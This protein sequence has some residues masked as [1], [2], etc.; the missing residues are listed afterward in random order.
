MD[1]V[2]LCRKVKETL[3]DLQLF[4]VLSFHGGQL[5]S[6]FFDRI[7]EGLEAP[8]FL[9]LDAIPGRGCVCGGDGEIVRE[10]V[11]PSK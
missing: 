2:D 3:P 1:V 4:R 5:C 8:L 9:S 11:K 6:K 7:F 10:D